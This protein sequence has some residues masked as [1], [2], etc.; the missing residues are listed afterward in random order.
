M[1]GIGDYL[2]A[3]NPN[4][5][6]CP[7]CGRPYGV[8]PFTVT[9]T[10][11]GQTGENIEENDVFDPKQH[12]IDGILAILGENGEHLRNFSLLDLNDLFLTIAEEFGENA[13]E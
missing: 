9:V 8:G 4:A 6:I 1:S 2:D 12:V 13:S 7:S 11:T 3:W 5:Y 10:S